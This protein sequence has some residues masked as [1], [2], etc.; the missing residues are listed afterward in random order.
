MV[1][2]SGATLADQAT[3]WNNLNAYIDG[4]PAL[5]AARG[6]VI[7]R[8]ASREPWNHSLDARLAQDI[9]VPGLKDHRLQITLDV[10]NVLNLINSEWGKLQY[11]SNQ[12]DTPIMFKGFDAATGKQKI[13]FSPRSRFALSQLASRWQMQLGLRYSFN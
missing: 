3:A 2:S 1:N 6:S 12:N 4:D 5:A 9:P 10:V 7:E 13:V 8:N 11:V